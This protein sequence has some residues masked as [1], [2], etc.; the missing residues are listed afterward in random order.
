M[1]N[2]LVYQDGTHLLPKDCKLKISPSKFAQFVQKPH[3]WYRSEILKEKGFTGNTSSVIGT[4]VHYCAEM[5]A[6]EL[7]VDKQIIQEYI[8]LFET[9]EDVDT[10]TVEISYTEMAERLINDYVLENVS[11]YFETE[12]F[13]Y[14][15]VA[16]GYYAGGTADFLEGS[17]EDTLIGDYKTY[18]SKIKPKAIPMSYK[19]QLLTLAWILSKNGYTPTR[20]RLVYINR[21]INGDI[22]KTTGKQLKS[23]PPE[24]TVLTETITEEDYEFID[25]LLGLCVDSVKASKKHPEL[26]HVIFHDMRLQKT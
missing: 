15:K 19:Y 10:S 12:K 4:I 16:D 14:A 3:Y 2:P 24:I 18:S 8:N 1:T 13:H 21:N 11:K 26:T 17:K 9:H 23:Y 7:P 22:S 20:I 25:S 6:K 5:V